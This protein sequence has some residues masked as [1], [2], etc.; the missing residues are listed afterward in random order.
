MMNSCVLRLLLIWMSNEADRICRKVGEKLRRPTLHAVILHCGTKS[1]RTAP[2]NT[3]TV[4]YTQLLPTPQPYLNF[5]T[6]TSKSKT[7]N[8]TLPKYTV[9]VHWRVV[10]AILLFC[11]S[12]VCFITLSS[13]TQHFLIAESYLILTHSWGIPYLITL[14][15]NSQILVHCWVIPNPN[16]LL[17]YTLSYYI[18]KKLPKTNTLLSYKQS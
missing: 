13:F 1:A 10:Y 9:S 5:V 16:T 14:L 12:T 17:R 7:S 2:P 3:L 18:A 11:W 4:S 8:N 15:R 6:R